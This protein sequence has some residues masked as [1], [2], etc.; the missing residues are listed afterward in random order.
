M[1]LFIRNS[2]NQTI[3]VAFGYYNPLCRPT[4]YRKAG[5]YRLDP[6]QTRQIW[7]G[8]AGGQTFYYYAE[9]INRTRV[10]QGPFVTRVPDTAFNVCWDTSNVNWDVIGMRSI[11]VGLFNFD[12]V[13]NFVASSSR[14]VTRDNLRSVLPSKKSNLKKTPAPV[15]KNLEKG[16][17]ILAKRTRLP[18]R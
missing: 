15:K 1:G 3:W 5:W 11:R 4:T 14:R 16:T 2:T 17:P 10:W 8:Y 13:I 7:S 18:K 9:N 6:G 12:F